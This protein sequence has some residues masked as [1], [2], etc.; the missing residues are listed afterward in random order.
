MNAF[1]HLNGLFKNT[2]TKED[3]QKAR[4]LGINDSALMLK[5]W[6][7]GNRVNNYL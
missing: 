5:Y 3:I 4:S 7:Q 6:N 2:I 1:D